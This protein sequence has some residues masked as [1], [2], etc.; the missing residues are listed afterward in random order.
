M[1]KKNKRRF[2]CVS[3]AQKKAIRKSY[4]EKLKIEKHRTTLVIDEEPVVN[5]KTKKAEPGFV[6]RE[7]THTA[8]KGFEKIE[9]NPDRTDKS[10]MYLKRP[11]KAPKRLFEPHNKKLVMP[12][13]LKNRYDKNNKKV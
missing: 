1:A 2:H 9:P 8:G 11:T 12:E 6:H 10:P 7:A 5:K 4:A 3:E 13:S